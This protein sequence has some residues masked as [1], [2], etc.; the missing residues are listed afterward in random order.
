MIRHQRVLAHFYI[1]LL[2]EKDCSSKWIWGLE[3]E[4]VWQFSSLLRFV[5]VWRAELVGNY[6]Y[7][8]TQSGL[9]LVLQ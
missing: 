1:C 4:R 7:T 2:E 8:A 5:Q 3:N 6:T 9:K